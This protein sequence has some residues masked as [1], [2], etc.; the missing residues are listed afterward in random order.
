MIAPRPIHTSRSLLAARLGKPRWAAHGVLA[1]LLYS[2][3]SSAQDEAQKPA[4][5]V[6]LLVDSSGS[7][8]FKTDGDFPACTPGDSTASEKSR[9]IDLVEVLTGEFEGYS[10]WAQPRNTAAFRSEFELSGVQ[11]YD[12]GYVNPYHRP[13]SN[14]CLY[15][16][17]VLPP[18]ASPYGWPSRYVNTFPLLGTP[19]TFTVSRP[20]TAALPS[21][22]GCADFSQ[23]NDGLLDTYA[24]LIRF[25]LMTFDARVSA[26]T[27]LSGASAN[28]ATGIDGNWSYYVGSPV[29]G[30]P[31]G[32][33]FDTDQEVGARNAAA[34]PW[35]G[36]MVAFGPPN[37]A[38]P[39]VRNRWI[40]DVLLS[41]RPY[42]ATPIAGQLDD[43]RQFLYNDTNPDPLNPSV[44]FG[45]R[46][47]L[48]WQASNCRKT[49]L[50]LLTD[51]EPN[52]DL[53]PYC[54]SSP[55]E[56]TDNC[57]YE[58]PKDIVQALR[59]GDGAPKSNMTVETYVIGFALASVTPSGSATAK[60]CALLTD[61]ECADPLNNVPD[62]ERSQNIQACCT[63]NEIAAAGGTDENNNPR[64]AYFASNRT[65]LKSV[66]ND[67]LDDVIQVATRTMPVFSSPGGDKAS[68]GYK[69]FSAFDPQ[70]DPSEPQ[71]WEG[72]LERR[73]YTCTDELEPKLEYDPE[74]GDDF[75]ANINSGTGL[76]RRFFTVIGEGND[77]VTS[78]RPFVSADEDGLGDHGGVTHIADGP[79]A[80][81]GEIPAEAMG[82]N[83]TTCA[84]DQTDA[85]CRDL[86][87]Q[88]L[89]GLT[90]AAGES[91]CSG[92]TC[93]LFG[94]IYHSVPTPVPGSPS[95]LLRD[96]S[97][98]SFITEM[99]E[100]K[101]P[102][103][104]YTSTVDGFL[105][106][107]KLAPHPKSS[108]GAVNT[109]TNNELW[110][111]LP[112]AVLPVLHSQYPN[113]PAVLLDG[114]PII[115]E[116]VATKDDASPPRVT[117]YERISDDAI[118]GGGAWRTLLV[119]GFGSTSEVGGGY[120][121]VDITEP[122][123]SGGQ[124]P[125]FRWQLTR[126]DSGAALF[127]KGGTP[128]I[129]TVFLDQDSDTEPAREV[130]VAVLP[131]GDAT[132][133]S[134]AQ[135]TTTSL[136]MDM[137]EG[138][139]DFKSTR[140]G[141]NYSYA[142]AEPAR[143][144]TIVRLDTG[145]VIR[146]FR[147]VQGPF[148]PEVW[149]E[150]D[151]DAPITGQPKAFPETAGSVA[152]RIYV[153]DRDGRLWRVDVSS[154]KP[155][156]WSMK[157]MYDAFVGEGA[158]EA[159]SQPVI[160]PPVLSVDEIGDVTIAFATGTQDPDSSANRVVSLT[161]RLNEDADFVTHLNWFQKLENHERVTGNMVLF[162]S[163]IYYSASRPPETTGA[164]CDVGSS[165]VYGVHYIESADHEQALEEGRSPK[166]E[167]GPA[168]APH[169]SSIVLASQPGLVFGVSV[170]A[171]PT[172]V[173]EIEEVGGNDSFGYG[174]VTRAKKVNP[175][176]YY[177][178]WSAS[179]NT[180]GSGT[181]S[182][183]VRNFD[184]E[185]PTPPLPVT[186]QSWALVYE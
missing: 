145:E 161:E 119:Q 45:P 31:E 54:E 125:V 4:P 124:E 184:D 110:A 77:S 160:L 115:K 19:P 170:Q 159:D 9:W 46:S 151:L 120:F 70:P 157:R 112:P 100:L 63:L 99:E 116:V 13:L 62:E 8:E 24:Q 133:I 51:G 150:T 123:R 182:R 146:T 28:Y 179:G 168:P 3:S 172:C 48:N 6:L 74:E 71:L 118:E 183:G 57:P 11:P 60:S 33:N 44:G 154:Q 164:A 80:V 167:T 137:D 2:G 69:F 55:S 97:Y 114:V 53:R 85:E 136:V 117:A 109:K 29:Q 22:T 39:T 103:V 26:G 76:Q 134:G 174:K 129:T 88:H 20:A 128:L 96:E 43:A 59:D 66:F 78:I 50:I 64:K 83:A 158:T 37:E 140:P 7:M 40:Q 186:F 176:K 162:D 163:V 1:L 89:V 147:P 152:D 177:L 87:I 32:C 156:Q 138:Q 84:G 79:G 173:D 49:I 15:G 148:K 131:G 132:P 180:T 113:T 65:E 35:E 166:P 171:Q 16:P 12:Y 165:K 107:F 41:T 25:G 130:A 61:E 101:R 23:R 95:E 94:G 27:G 90:N 141:R 122:D 17:G 98:S 144:L 86:I 72:I 149:T 58:K 5:N 153:G 67:I 93:Q 68:K 181:D 142:E 42:G 36:R 104:L 143:S 73:R 135:S 169:E 139:S 185:L 111:F 108:T 102:S 127:G 175:G 30:R 81:A 18:A 155:E 34:P 56:T 38:D 121:A 126:D 47:D 14:N 106:A 52:L 91:R 92:G 82:I 10:C 105:H 75:T 21:Y 178:S